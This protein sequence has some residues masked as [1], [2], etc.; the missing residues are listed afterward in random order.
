MT[1]MD[2]GK[3][4]SIFYFCQKCWQLAMAIMNEVDKPSNARRWAN[5]F[6]LQFSLRKCEHFRV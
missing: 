1:F 4:N 5:Y 3:K 6:A 2:G